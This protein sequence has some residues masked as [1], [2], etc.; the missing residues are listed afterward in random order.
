MAAAD[1]EQIMYEYSDVIS[2]EYAPVI[3]QEEAIRLSL[4]YLIDP[5][6]FKL[7]T[8]AH[9]ANI[10]EK[11]END[12]EFLRNK[13]PFL[14]VNAYRSIFIEGVPGS[15]KSSAV[16]KTLTDILHK[17]HTDILKKVVVVS[18]SKQNSERLVKDLGMD[19][20]TI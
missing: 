18:N 4:S 12:P 14:Y 7:F 1:P 17:F 20:S 16:L 9:N 13:A 19:T 5:K 11:A 15:G 2:A 3:G 8:D 6:V 10:L